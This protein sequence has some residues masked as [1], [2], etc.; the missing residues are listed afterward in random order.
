MVTKKR[1]IYNKIETVKNEFSGK[2][3]NLGEVEPVR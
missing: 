2:N 1:M 3:T